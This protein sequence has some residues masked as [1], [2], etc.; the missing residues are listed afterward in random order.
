M[1]TII[2]SMIL[3]EAVL[4]GFFVHIGEHR[5]LG[6]AV[7]A[8]THN[9]YIIDIAPIFTLGIHENCMYLKES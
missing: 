5:R 1:P 7:S 4:E 8:R 6:R 2:E 3:I 9:D